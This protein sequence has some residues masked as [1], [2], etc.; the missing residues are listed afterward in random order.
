MACALQVKFCCGYTQLGMSLKQWSVVIILSSSSAAAL[1]LPYSWCTA[2]KEK[3]MPYRKMTHKKTKIG[4]VIWYEGV[5][6]ACLDAIIKSLYLPVRFYKKENYWVNFCCQLTTVSGWIAPLRVQQN[7]K[8]CFALSFIITRLGNPQ[9]IINLFFFLCQKA[10]YELLKKKHYAIYHFTTCEHQAHCER[11]SQTIQK[12]L[13]SKKR[14]HAT[15]Y[16]SIAH[17]IM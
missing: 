4:L 12:F 14:H 16:P 1:L 9:C 6:G 10:H 3:S 7:S 17:G 11:A 8:M 2:F 5:F 13:K 15:P